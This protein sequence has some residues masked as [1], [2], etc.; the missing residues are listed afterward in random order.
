VIDIFKILQKYSTRGLTLA[1]QSM[2]SNVLNA[3]KRKNLASDDYSN[4][5]KKLNENI[6]YYTE[7]ILGLPEETLES[8]K[9]GL[10]N[11]LTLGLHDRIE[12]WLTDA[13]PNSELASP[14]TI[15]KYNLNLKLFLII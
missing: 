5:F 10:T 4:L 9:N 7:F 6:P 3:V 8:W 14:Y 2:S 12:F 11:L 13:L 1:T 15:K